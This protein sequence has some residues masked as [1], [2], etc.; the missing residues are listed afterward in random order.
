MLV[1]IFVQ[2][3]DEKNAH[4][5]DCQ[6]NWHP[7]FA[8]AVHYVLSADNQADLLLLLRLVKLSGSS[9]GLQRPWWLRQQIMFRSCA[10]YQVGK[11][12]PGDL[13]PAAEGNSPVVLA[14][15]GGPF[16]QPLAFQLAQAEAAWL[17]FTQLGY[18]VCVLSSA[19]LNRQEQDLD[20]T[21]PIA[22]VTPFLSL[23][24]APNLGGP[25]TQMAVT[26]CDDLE[27]R[28]VPRG[29]RTFLLSFVDLQS[30]RADQ[31]S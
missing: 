20:K 3:I 19:L 24:R 17:A 23:A 28:L 5:G 10:R 21:W 6:V 30:W 27:S 31:Q 15:Q 14:V 11:R 8:V 9:S 22:R 18:Q 12:V 2:T 26:I 4:S 7:E 29:R 25:E 16:S 1:H 13:D